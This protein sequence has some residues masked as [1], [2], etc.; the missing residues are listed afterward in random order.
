MV[1]VEGLGLVVCLLVEVELCAR[2]RERSLGM[3]S[4]DRETSIRGSVATE[5]QCT[6]S[7]LSA[8]LSGP[9]SA[10]A[11]VGMETKHEGKAGENPLRQ[12]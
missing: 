6:K 1:G 10:Y 7:T 3:S 5:T 9:E 8:N 2:R 11:F 12:R 4:V